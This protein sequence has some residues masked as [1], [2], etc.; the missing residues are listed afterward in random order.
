MG[1][2][3]L[4]SAPTWGGR[5]VRCP[6]LEAQGK[7]GALD[8]ERVC[9]RTNRHGWKQAEVAGHQSRTQAATAWLCG[10]VKS[11]NFSGFHF[12]LSNEMAGLDLLFSFQ[13]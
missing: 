12:P 4:G 8:P 11:L 10:F 3:A 5:A 13:L 1:T 9:S 2:I 7:A 6:Q